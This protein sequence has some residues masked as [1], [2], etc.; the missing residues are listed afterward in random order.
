MGQAVQSGEEYRAL[1]S[2]SVRLPGGSTSPAKVGT[3]LLLVLPGALTVYL[4]FNSGGMFEVPPAFAAC[5]VLIALA[6]GAAVAREPLAGVAPR[7][8]LA[9]GPL[10]LFA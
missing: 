5:V 9:C 10:G 2:R 1:N 7:G 3:A 4:A 6:L 8:L